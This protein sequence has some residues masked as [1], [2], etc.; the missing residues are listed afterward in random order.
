MTNFTINKTKEC[1]TH[2]RISHAKVIYTQNKRCAL[3]LHFTIIIFT[4]LD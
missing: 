4:Q 1:H 3:H 2:V